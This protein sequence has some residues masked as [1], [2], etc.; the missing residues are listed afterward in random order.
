MDTVVNYLNSSSNSAVNIAVIILSAAIIQQILKAVLIKGTNSITRQNLF[1][2]SED[3]QRRIKTINS[4]IGATVAFAVWSVAAIMVME[5]LNIP[6]APILTS[7]GIIGAALAF[8]SQSLVKDFVSGI[9]IIAENQYKVDD[10][11]KIGEVSGKVE[12]ITMRTTTLRDDNGTVL[13]IPNGSITTTRNKSMGKIKEYIT[14]EIAN[15][16]NLAS[17][18]KALTVIADSLKNDETT[19][20]LIDEGPSISAVQK[21]TSNSVTVLVEIKTDIIHS[22][23]A[24]SALWRAIHKAAQKKQIKLI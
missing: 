6:I 23:E 16:T 1:K 8:G 9:F 20:H 24:I 5:I 10:Y 18:A 13:F 14:L 15:E 7:A 19:A 12:G 3:R 11:V 2:T 4:I 17:F 21:V 22:E